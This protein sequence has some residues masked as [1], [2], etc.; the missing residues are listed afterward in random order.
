[1]IR[2]LGETLKAI[3]QDPSVPPELGA[4]DIL[5]DRPSDPF[6]LTKTTID[7]FLYDVRENT[8]LRS[9]EYVVERRNNQSI[10]H[11]APLRLNCSYLV[12]AWPVG[13]PE[14]A[15]Q[16]HRL[17]TQALRA[18]GQFPIIPAKYLQGSL[19]GQEPPLPM[20]ALHPDAL[21]N[22]S[23]FWTSVGNKLRASL[24]V[25]VTIGV[26]LFA[27]VADFMVTTRT[28]AVAPAETGSPDTFV[29]VGGRVLDLAARGIAGALVDILD[30]TLQETGLRET[31]DAEGRFSF[32]RVPTGTQNLRAVASG[33]Q[34]K[35]QQLVVPGRQEDYEITLAPL[36]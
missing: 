10:I 33:F 7:L 14:I 9:N 5:F 19:V 13:G 36:P 29:Q 30:A 26:P 1:M 20:M 15:L 24:T 18:L 11:P 22:L 23:E 21:K 3:L 6:T 28:T 34:D 16:E 25:T 17:L 12:T 27:D 32:V 8:E 31:T 35:T 4:A 2:D